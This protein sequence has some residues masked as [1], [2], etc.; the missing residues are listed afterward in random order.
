[1]AK[2]IAHHGVKGQRWGVRR[3]QNEDGSL[4]SAGRKRYDVNDDGTANLKGKYRS[5][6][7]IK[8]TVKTLIGASVATSAGMKVFNAKKAKTNFTSRRGKKKLNRA[9]FGAALGSI[10]VAS[11]VKNFINANKNKTINSVGMGGTPETFTGKA[12]TRN[13]VIAKNNREN[14]K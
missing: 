9:I 3:F 11:G 5:N 7:N 10:V 14:K 12:K 4:T 13:Q 6:Q 2:Y 8:G 1:M